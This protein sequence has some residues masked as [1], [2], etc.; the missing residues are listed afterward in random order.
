MADHKQKMEAETNA[1]KR[2][3]WA[4]KME[5]WKNALT[6]VANLKGKEPKDRLETKFIDDIVTDIYRQLGVPLRS[7][8]SQ[9]PQ[10]IGIDY[11]IHFLSSWLQDRSEHTA[12]I[13]TI[14]GMGGIGK[15]SLAK[16][17]YKLHFR[18]FNRSS[19]VE[20]ISRRCVEQSNGLLD[21]Q[22]QLC[23]DISKASLN[24]VNDISV[25]TSAIEN[26]L[27][28]KKVFVVLDDIDSL[29]QLDV[30]LGN[31][32]F[33]PESKIIIT[34]KDASLTER[35]A[36][37]NPQVQP[38]HTKHNLKALSV[39]DSLKL[40]CL[41]A[42]KSEDIKEGYEAVSDN[43]VNYCKGHPLA[44]IVLGRSLRNRD[45][46][47]WE[48]CIAGLKKEP[49]SNI[50][51]V[52]R[53]SFESLPSKNDR[54]LFKHIA[55]FFVGIDRDFIESILRACNINTRSGIT[56]LI[57]RCLLHIDWNNVLS[58]H[59]LIQEMGRD[60]VRQESPD[61]PWKRS[62]L[63]CHEESF[64]VLKQKKGKGNLLGLSLD[65]R[66]LEKEKLR[67]SSDLKT[68]AFSNMGSLMI[69]H[70]DYVQII[71]TYE[72][73]P[74]E[75]RWLRMCGFPL[76]SIPSE[77]PMDN[78]VA[79]DMSYSK[80]EY[81]DMSCSNIGSL[82][83]SCSSLQRPEKRQKLTESFSKAE[84]LLGS[85]KIL[86]L[87]FSERLRG[88]GGFCELPSLE[89]LFLRNCM[90]LVEV[91]ESID[92]CD[93]L[94]FI[95]LSNCKELIRMHP[96]MLAKLKKVEKLVLDGCNIGELGMEV[97][98]RDSKSLAIYLPSSLVR[99]SLA[100]N[101][102][103][104]ESFPMDFSCLS[105]LTELCLD[106]NPIVSMPSCVRSLPRLEILSLH[107]CEMLVSIEH[108]PRTLKALGCMVS[109]KRIKNGYYKSL[110]QKIAFDPE[111]S[112]LML[113]L[114]VYHL[115]GSS[116][117]IEGMI[118]IQP[119]AGI[120]DTILYSL[121]WS[122]LKFI[123]KRRVETHRYQR[124][125]EESQTQ[126]YYEFGIFST[127]YAGEVMPTLIRRINK[128][129]FNFIYHSIIS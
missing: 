9:D 23:D 86:D 59:S 128:G 93:E 126:M 24:R 117:E 10:L 79:L 105:M 85:L 15:T 56:H 62:R 38:K 110:I 113:G 99:L 81:F 112:P 101:K 64:K 49:D 50:N 94:V 14:L 4:Q 111:M 7:I 48:D 103:S 97:V 22:K 40:F 52:L 123:N 57:D 76:K 33:H 27:S 106:G 115:A 29:D 87:S 68:A 116:I 6:Q 53:M 124:G 3:E 122:Y 73:F 13:L 42:F 92:H 37:F 74:E 58:M 95:D 1:E 83:T 119:I 60:A 61:K 114:S 2:N 12:D 80:I 55:C 102:L 18:E 36:L 35:C 46:A 25:Y 120:D 88:V 96:R 8:L 109:F 98:P 107:E 67:G 43:I 104:N 75:L 66:M 84:R 39:T 31:K 125:E 41:Y 5:I 100:N 47:Y 65:M 71:G 16:H 28:H 30:L 20:N 127:V 63:W 45:V 72:S 21:V 26:A 118:K 108:P 70:L 69:L 51:S 19:F 11:S 32:G 17:V 77:L 44:L 121:G 54:E 89:S 91:S 78:L 82:D 129:G 90:S 34:T